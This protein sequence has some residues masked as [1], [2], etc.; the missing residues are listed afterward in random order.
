[1]Q[2]T[3]E[4]YE[5]RIFNEFMKE[6]PSM[7]NSKSWKTLAAKYKE[8]ADYKMVFPKLP[9][10]QQNYFKNWKASQDW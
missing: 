10:M 2:A 1:M 6:N 4:V 5:K 7:P 9:S 3:T 8:K